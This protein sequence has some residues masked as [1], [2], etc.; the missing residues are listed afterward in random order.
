MAHIHL[1]TSQ[2]ESFLARSP[3]FLPDDCIE[4]LQL[5]PVRE[6]A[7]PGALDAGTAGTAGSAGRRSPSSSP[8]LMQQK[9]RSRGM[10]TA[11]ESEWHS[12]SILTATIIA[13]GN[14]GDDAAYWEETVSNLRLYISFFASRGG[15]TSPFGVGD[16]SSGSSPSRSAGMAPPLVLLFCT[17]S[18]PISCYPSFLFLVPRY[19]YAF[20]MG[21]FAPFLF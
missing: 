18:G 13:G 2:P 9:S 16:A 6:A 1:Y 10:L 14:A 21:F 7:E 5:S 15:N 3:R 8:S 19:C 20:I 4:L 12:S 11:K 17:R